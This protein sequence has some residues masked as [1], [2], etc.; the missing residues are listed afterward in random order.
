M[1]SPLILAMSEPS[2]NDWSFAKRPRTAS[3]N[4]SD[5]APLKSM[6]DLLF[7]P[8]D[9]CLLMKWLI[10]EQNATLAAIADFSKNSL[11]ATAAMLERL[12]EQGFVKKL[13]TDDRYES[14]VVTRKKRAV[15]REIK[16]VLGD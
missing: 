15:P 5:A 1:H 11:E 2:Q 9:E 10:N 8:D 3:E 14:R 7:L 4:A 6:S 13:D 16:P 12:T